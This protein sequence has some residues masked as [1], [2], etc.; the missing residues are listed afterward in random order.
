MSLAFCRR[1]VAAFAV[2]GLAAC[3]A[4]TV[5]PSST[6]SGYPSA[7]APAAHRPFAMTF[8]ARFSP[9]AARPCNIS[10]IWYFKGSCVAYTMRS[11]GGTAKL[12]T[13]KGRAYSLGFPKNNAPANTKFVIGDGTSSADIRGTLNG[14]PFPI[15]GKVPC[16]DIVKA[17]IV[18]CPG[19]A[20]VYNLVLNGSSN[21]VNF[22]GT[23]KIVVT[24]TGLSDYTKC[25]LDILAHSASQYVW[26][27][28]PVYATPDTSSSSSPATAIFKPYSV[29]GGLNFTSNSFIVLG[30]ACQ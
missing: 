6:Q 16:Y 9:A 5:V 30:V 23:P 12:K 11:T 1:V 20:I 19:Q 3:A 21:T 10:G 14:A 17:A 18:P 28:L 4:Q 27:L 7:A 29:P 2:T 26:A 25:Q 13:F 24:Y 22:S 15:Y 8:Q